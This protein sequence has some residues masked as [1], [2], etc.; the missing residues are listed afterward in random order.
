[1]YL[2]I[3]FVYIL[4]KRFLHDAIYLEIIRCFET[5][6]YRSKSNCNYIYSSNVYIKNRKQQR[7]KMVVR[8]T[9]IHFVF[10]SNV[11]Y[12]HGKFLHSEIKCLQTINHVIS[13]S[14]V[15]YVG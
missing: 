14:A 3:Y 9:T 6:K 12:S 7:D 5:R 15:I 10:T 4:L 1:M 11:Q 8:N 13:K 2:L